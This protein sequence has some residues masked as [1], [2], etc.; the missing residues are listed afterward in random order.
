MIQPS[1]EKM[2]RLV[3]AL[4]ISGLL[5]VVILSLLLYWVV[6]ER[7]PLPYFEQ[8]PADYEEQLAPLADDR[9]SGEVI[10]AFKNLPFEQLVDKLHDTQLVENGFTQRD[11]ALAALVSFYH[12]DLTR[13]LAGHTQPR[14][15]RG[16]VCKASAEGKPVH[17]VAYPGLS[18]E[19]FNEIIR[20]IHTERWP[21]TSK[22]LFVLLQNHQEAKSVADAFLM[23]SEFLA[24][25]MLFNRSHLSIQKRELLNVIRE[26]S[27]KLLKEFFQKQRVTNDL[28]E[29]RRQKFLLDYIK[30]G[31]QAAA[32]LLLKT[33]QEFATKKLDDRDVLLILELLTT[34]TV[35]SE[36][37]AL[38]LLTSPRTNAVWM[39]STARLY[40]YAG[41]TIPER[42]SYQMAL[43]RFAPHRLIAN[44]L[45]SVIKSSSPAS[46]P[47]PIATAP[48]KT[49]TPITSSNSIKKI[50]PIPAIPSNQVKP[51]PTVA[52][53]DL[54]Y[55]VQ[56]GDSLWKIA[57]RFSV[58]I[59][60]LKAR[61]QLK[62]DLL[63]PGTVLKIPPKIS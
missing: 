13:A 45:D 63:K 7:V 62:T 33:D 20:F 35:E 40:Q 10:T 27:W 54:L 9:S 61:N 52:P 59:D 29:A 1:P 3:R 46:S 42:W 57:R 32:Y 25:E 30:Q 56:E 51:Q 2:G 31:S 24:V 50:P 21:I 48:T 12:F 34:K 17:W 11:L 44:S 41:E 60:G 47:A 19:Q 23:T 38:E 26:G 55:I 49:L 14:Q 5:N 4:V 36:K 18:E 53:K 43:K 37:Y 22:G 16:F 8:R 39:K 58:S 28:S 15:K 6:K